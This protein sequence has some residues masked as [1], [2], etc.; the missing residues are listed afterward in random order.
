MELDRTNRR[1]STINL[2]IAVSNTE[3]L[4]TLIFLSSDW[5]SMISISSHVFNVIFVVNYHLFDWSSHLKRWSMMGIKSVCSMMYWLGLNL[6]MAIMMRFWSMIMSIVYMMRNLARMWR[7]MAYMMSFVCI[8]W[9]IAAIM[10][11]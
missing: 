11:S 5:T 1:I 6:L 7:R 3:S 8:S 2:V 10:R 9:S 4:L